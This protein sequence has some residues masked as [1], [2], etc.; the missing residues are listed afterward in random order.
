MDMFIAIV[1]IAVGALMLLGCMLLPAAAASAVMGKLFAPPP[2]SL[3]ELL[4]EREIEQLLA[5]TR[6]YLRSQGLR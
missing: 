5:E 3:D 2:P 1:V 4:E 6:D